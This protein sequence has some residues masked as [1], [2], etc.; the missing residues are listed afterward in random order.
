[1]EES[2]ELD[3]MIA[4]SR[5]TLLRH[6]LVQHVRRHRR[7]QAY[8]FSKAQMSVEPG[9]FLEVF[10]TAVKPILLAA[11]Q[12]RLSVSKEQLPDIERVASATTD[13]TRSYQPHIA[14]S[15]LR[16]WSDAGATPAAWLDAFTVKVK[17]PVTDHL[18]DDEIRTTPAAWASSFI[19]TT[20][21]EDVEV[22]LTS[23]A[24]NTP[25]FWWWLLCGRLSIASVF[26]MNPSIVGSPSFWK[27]TIDPADFVAKSTYYE[28]FAKRQT[29]RST[30]VAML[31]NDR[32]TLTTVA[33]APTIERLYRVAVQTATISR[34]QTE[35]DARIAEYLPNGGE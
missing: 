9:Q 18:Q 17:P 8:L 10:D 27:R 15:L 7:F 19:F 30:R 14:R 1:M 35:H 20:K 28:R 11:E 4:H 16:K 24:V 5:R 34:G 33:A 3:D 13:S 32:L 12:C 22:D 23:D 31:V 26:M 25:L 21:P 6:H 29:T 2:M